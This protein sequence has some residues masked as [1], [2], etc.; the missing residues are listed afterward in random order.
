MKSFLLSREPLLRVVKSIII[1]KELA[2]KLGR[3]KYYI[4]CL[5]CVVLLRV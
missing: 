1:M 5:V 2:T 3:L 4:W